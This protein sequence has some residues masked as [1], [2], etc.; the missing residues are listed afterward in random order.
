MDGPVTLSAATIEEG[1]NIEDVIPSLEIILSD[2]E[3]HVDVAIL[4]YYQGLL[5]LCNHLKE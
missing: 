1:S 3:K 2:V 4:S 5:S